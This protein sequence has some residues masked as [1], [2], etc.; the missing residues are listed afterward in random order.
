MPRQLAMIGDIYSSCWGW[1]RCSCRCVLD[2]RQLSALH[3]SVTIFIGY[4]ISSL[5]QRLIQPT[6][7]EAATE[8]A[9]EAPIK[10]AEAAIEAA[11]ASEV[12][13][14]AAAI[15]AAATEEAAIKTGALTEEAAAIK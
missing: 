7:S 10:A 2:K 13:T 8:A 3:P 15:K 14:E 6:E 4:S 5:D 1:C 9:P 11:A 12:A